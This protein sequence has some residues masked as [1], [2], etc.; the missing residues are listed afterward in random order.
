[1]IRL[2]Q[3]RQRLGAAIKGAYIPGGLR[4]AIEQDP[5]FALSL[6]MEPIDDVAFD[7]DDTRPQD[8]VALLDILQR[9][10]GIFESAAL[11]SQFGRDENA[12]CFGVVWP[13]I[14]LAVL[15]HGQSHWRPESV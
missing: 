14:E 2:A 8:D 7:Y 1:M 9:V 12:W 13:L 10:K 15:L 4:D 3:L 11:C 5:D 6:S